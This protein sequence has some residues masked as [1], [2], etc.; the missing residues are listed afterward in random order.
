MLAGAMA[1]AQVG[2]TGIPQ[3]FL[4]GL[5]R[6][7]ALQQLAYALASKMPDTAMQL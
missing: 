1:G 7:D 6:A 4:D 2:L 3:R 5:Q